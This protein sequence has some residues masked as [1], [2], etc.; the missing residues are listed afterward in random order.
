MAAIRPLPA[1]ALLLAALAGLAC[2]PRYVRQQVYL[3]NEVEVLLRAEKREGEIVPRG[4]D[5]PAPIAPVRVANILARVDKRAGEVE[6]SQR[7]PAVPT[8]L[9]FEIADGMAVALGEATPDQEVVVL[10]QRRVRHLKLFTRRRLTSLVAWMQDD[11]LHLD[12]GHLDWELDREAEDELPEPFAGKPQEKFRIL[13]GEHMVTTGPQSVAVAWRDDV[14]R[15]SSALRIAPGGELMRRTILM[16]EP[17]E[18]EPEASS[19]VPLPADLTPGEL[20]ALADLEESRRAG[21]LTESEYQSRRRE[22]L[23]GAASP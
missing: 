5:H 3:E 7:G 13:P 9:I 8:E 23:T 10:A 22:I 18:P 1:V 4:F 6:E 21:E 16:E 12:F 14:F 17:P 2:G 15:D 19:P 11:R 20:R